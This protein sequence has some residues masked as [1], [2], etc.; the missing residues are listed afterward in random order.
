MRV[1]PRTL[2]MVA[3]LALAFYVLL[4][5]LAN[6]G[7]S[8]RAMRD[9]NWGWLAVAVVFSLLTYVA[10]A[11]GMAGG[12]PDPLPPGATTSRPSSR[13]ASSTGSPRPTSAG[14]P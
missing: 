5:Q 12:V 2:L 8:V 3:A 7:D 13:P 10:S 11:V 14:W 1:R 4:P 6:V 9:A